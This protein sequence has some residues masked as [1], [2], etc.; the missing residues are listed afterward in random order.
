MTDIIT[1]IVNGEELRTFEN[2]ELTSSMQSMSGGFSFTYIPKFKFVRN[3]YELQ[4]IIKPQDEVEIYINNIQYLT[5]YV[6]DI[7]WS[8]D[9][10][11][12]IITISG[13]DKIGYV[14]DSYVI[15][16]AYTETNYKKLIELVLRDNG[17]GDVISVQNISSSNLILSAEDDI[18][19][20][21]GETIRDFMDRYAAKAQVL[22]GSNNKGELIIYREG[23]VGSVA[24]RFPT[25]SNAPIALINNINDQR[26]N[27]LQSTFDVSIRDRYRVVEVYSQSSRNV[28]DINNVSPTAIATDSLVSTPRRVRI[29]YSNS[30]NESTL[31]ELAKWRVNLKRAKSIVYRCRLQGISFSENNKDYWK[32]NTYVQVS[33]DQRDVNG[34]FLIESVTFTKSNNG[35]FTDLS[36]VNRGS[37]TLDT[38][39][40]IKRLKRNNF[41]AIFQ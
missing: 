5:G 28:H 18:H 11:S 17:W 39:R 15:P 10:E 3:R 4:G 26:K 25:N 23:D 7:S 38:E 2:I 32:I 20:E 30:A 9:P 19:A 29:Q 14:L 1:L 8:Q 36:I 41:G 33:D 16:R 35:T 37:Y 22:L 27:I 6:D 24:G 31:V 21:S 12:D 34:D 40:A 13:R